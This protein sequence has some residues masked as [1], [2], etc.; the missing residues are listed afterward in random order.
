LLED[1]AELRDSIDRETPP[2]PEREAA[3]RST[4]DL[5]RQ[6]QRFERA[7]DTLGPQEEA[8]RAEFGR[9]TQAYGRAAND[10]ERLRGDPQTYAEFAHI[11]RTMDRLAPEF[12]GYSRYGY[13]YDNPGHGYRMRGP[14]IDL[15][16]GGFNI[17]VGH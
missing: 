7:V 15:G 5:Q 10:V 17:H 9:L 6:A 4:N 12:G 16:G 8:T 1:T 11:R 2:G 13:Q 3:L 14:G